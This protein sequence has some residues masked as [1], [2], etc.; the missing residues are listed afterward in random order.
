M[1][2]M[3]TMLILPTNVRII[4]LKFLSIITITKYQKKVNYMR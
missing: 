3:E 2:S 4:Y 1:H